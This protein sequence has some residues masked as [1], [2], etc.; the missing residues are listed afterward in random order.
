MPNTITHARIARVA[1]LVDRV[2]IKIDNGNEIYLFS[3][4]K[5]NT[6]LKP[7]QFIGLTLSQAIGLRK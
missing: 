5:Q 7:E 3:C 2:Y 4:S 1:P 6:D